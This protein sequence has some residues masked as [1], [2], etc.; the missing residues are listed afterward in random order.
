MLKHFT[1][2]IFQQTKIVMVSL[3]VNAH[4]CMIICQK[5][6]KWFSTMDRKYS[7]YFSQFCCRLVWCSLKPYT[8]GICPCNAGF[9]RNY[10]EKKFCEWKKEMGSL[11]FDW[12]R[13]F[14]YCRETKILHGF[15]DCRSK[16][17]TKDEYPNANFFNW[18]FPY[19][20]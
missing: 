11:W 2:S 10:F 16:T 9:E 17:E 1:Q 14:N 20:F 15:S 12:I 7:V 19:L 4:G 3:S 5:M 18:K 8:V 6:F 13:F